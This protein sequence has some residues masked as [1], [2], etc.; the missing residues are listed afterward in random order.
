MSVECSECE[1]SP[2]AG[3]RDTCSRHPL[4]R[5]IRELES[6]LQ[7]SQE[8]SLSQHDLWL[9]EKD[10][11]LNLV[12]QLS[13]VHSD[14]RVLKD[15]NARLHERL[16]DNYAFD[17]NGKRVT[18]AP[19]TIPDGIE[20]REVTIR[21]LESSLR[22]WKDW[23]LDRAHEL[24]EERDRLKEKLRLAEIDVDG[25]EDLRRERNYLVGQCKAQEVKID[26]LQMEIGTVHRQGCPSIEKG[27][28]IGNCCETNDRYFSRPTGRTV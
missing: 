26:R 23:A 3:H 25:Y 16:E 7:L 2:G 18:I 15:E 17:K 6:A 1:H 24:E 10:H 11:S 13:K 28:V 5:R 20:C 8:D 12:K 21:E 14:N 22:K 27:I 4:Q 19:G 9:K